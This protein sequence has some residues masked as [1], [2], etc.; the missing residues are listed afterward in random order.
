MT[1][2]N[3]TE[4]DIL[5]AIVRKGALSDLC[6]ELNAPIVASPSPTKA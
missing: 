2:Q 3:Q 6:K 5:R 1:T 4:N